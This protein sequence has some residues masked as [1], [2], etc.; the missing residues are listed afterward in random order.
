MYKY[1]I[2]NTYGKFFFL[3]YDPEKCAQYYCNKHVVKIPIEIAQLLSKIQFELME[4][5][6][7]NYYYKNPQMIAKT[8]AIYVWIKQSR[9]NY[10]WAADLGL[11]LINE[12]KYRYDKSSHKTE[13]VLLKLREDV[14]KSLPNIP[15]TEF[16]MTNKYDMYQYLSSNIL[17]NCRYFYV[18]VKCKNDKWNKR[19]KPNWYIDI[20]NE[21]REKKQKLKVKIYN[22]INGKLHTDLKLSSKFILRLCYDTL[23]Q[24]K[25]QK[26]ATLMNRYFKDIK[27]FR[28][29]NYTH[30]YFILEIAKQM[31]N[32]NNYKKYYIQSSKYR[33]RYDMMNYPSDKIDYQTNPEYYVYT[34]NNAG[35]FIVEPYSSLLL[36][37]FSA[38]SQDKLEE[39]LNILENK[40]YRFINDNDML[41]LD[42]SRKLTK[43][44][45]TILKSYNKKRNLPQDKHIFIGDYVYKN[46]LIIKLI[47]KL[48]MMFNNIRNNKDYRKWINNQNYMNTDPYTPK[49]YI[50]QK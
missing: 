45:Y 12:Y 25:W 49:R 17:R 42:M 35:L 44:L 15:M 29:L 40:I 5:E 48:Y 24:G 13:A 3:D 2:I 37:D 16:I 47:D 50:M 1:I 30:L 34:N 6:N 46:D 26:K 33:K 11:A 31:E 10:I 9:A 18:D 8:I 41:G 43:Y 38:E 20:E 4:S 28:Q 27:L 14:P 19:N 22:S 32:Y 39:S 7:L 36:N 23:F 21:L